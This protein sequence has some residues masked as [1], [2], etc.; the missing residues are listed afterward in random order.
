MAVYQ[1]QNKCRTKTPIQEEPKYIDIK[2]NGTN[3][4]SHN[5]KNAAIKLRINAE[6]KHLYKKNP[7]TSISKSTEQTKGYTTPKTQPSNSE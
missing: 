6:L 7:N 1:T 3:E 4:K 2:V 5:T